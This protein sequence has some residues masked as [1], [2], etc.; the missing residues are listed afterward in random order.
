MIKTL[1]ERILE[2]EAREKIKE[3]LANYS[4]GVDKRDEAV[5]IDLWEEEAV[6]DQGNG[7]CYINKQ[8]ILQGVK[9]AW[10]RFTNTYH[11]T[12]NEVIQVDLKSGTASSIA[13][14]DTRVTSSAG[15]SII[16]SATYYDKF[17]MTNGTWRFTERKTMIHR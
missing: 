17:R 4:H 16:I 12:M 1:E 9:G 10:E 3:I 8:E 2:L 5:F 15:N 11:Y 13:D 14:V 7:Q 6:W